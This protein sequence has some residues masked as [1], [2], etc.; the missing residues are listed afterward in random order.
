VRTHT[1]SLVRG[2]V[3]DPSL[4][5]VDP[6]RYLETAER[7]AARIRSGDEPVYCFRGARLKAAQDV[8]QRRLIHRTLQERRQVLPCHAG[9]L[10]LVL[11]ATGELFPCED[12]RLLMG[13]I[14][15]HD[16]DLART[17]RTPRAKAIVKRIRRGGCWCTHECFMMTNV[18]FSPRCYP[19]LL[20]E[21]LRLLVR[22]R[23][24]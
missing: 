10:N 11:S 17:E 21:Y 6:A 16:C 22:R 20:G 14:R 23:G 15:D 18:L 24:R 3:P 4:A 9:R 1:V 7:L 19:A 12:F 2:E 13:N 8:L 5:E